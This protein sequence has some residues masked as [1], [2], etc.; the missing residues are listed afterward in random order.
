[1]QLCVQG[2]LVHELIN[3]VVIPLVNTK[4]QQGHNV[5]VPNPAEQIQLI[6]PTTTAPK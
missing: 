6:L 4:A 2:S 1:M 3:N 5:G